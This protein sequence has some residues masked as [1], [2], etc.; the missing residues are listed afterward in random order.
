MGGFTSNAWCF[1][2]R[3]LRLSSSLLETS[4]RLAQWDEGKGMWIPRSPHEVSPMQGRGKAILDWNI[5]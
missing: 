1:H 3:S 2:T 5:Y 4:Q